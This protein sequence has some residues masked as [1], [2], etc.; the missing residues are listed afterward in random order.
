MT[1]LSIIC[2]I[3]LFSYCATICK[4]F[5][6]ICLLYVCL[7]L[8]RQWIV[9]WAHRTRKTW[10]NSS[11]SLPWRWQNN[12]KVLLHPWNLVS[13]LT[14]WWCPLL[15]L[16]VFQTVQVIVQARLGEKISTCSS[17]SPTGSD[18]V[19]HV[20]DAPYTMGPVFFT[21]WTIINSLCLCVSLCS[22]SLIWQ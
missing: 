19:R 8:M 21:S 16:C 11:N 22:L 13:Q 2:V 9:I 12:T 3:Y 6:T 1:W 4:V 14:G 7:R 20:Q 10:I 18:W 15:Y 5:A 17:S